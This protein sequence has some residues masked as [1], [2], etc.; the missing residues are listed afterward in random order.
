M[1]VE[2][3]P[4]MEPGMS[5][6]AYHLTRLIGRLGSNASYYTLNHTNGH[7]DNVIIVDRTT[8]QRIIIDFAE[9]QPGWP[10]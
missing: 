5:E 8:G 7:C 1:N 3:L 4:P 10:Q 2:H 6:H 9:P